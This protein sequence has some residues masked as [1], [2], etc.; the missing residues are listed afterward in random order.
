M[1]ATFS[2]L[3]DPLNFLTPA[4]VQFLLQTPPLLRYIRTRPYSFSFTN[5][6]RSRP[7]ILLQTICKC[8]GMLKPRRLF[9]LSTEIRTPR[10]MDFRGKKRRPPRIRLGWP[11]NFKVFH[12]C[13]SRCGESYTEVNSMGGGSSGG[14]GQA[15]HSR[16]VCALL[17]PPSPFFLF[18]FL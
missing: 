15:L 4:I 16:R 3:H 8:P 1:H 11:R 18:L 14:G 12:E 2:S 5:R 13:V 9:P 7:Q 10:G 6:V 17:F